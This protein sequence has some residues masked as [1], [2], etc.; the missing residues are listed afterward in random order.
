MKLFQWREIE[1]AVDYAAQG[2]QALHIH[3]FIID[4]DKAPACFKRDVDAGKQIA[5]LFDQDKNRL[6]ATARRLGVR[7]ILVEREGTDGMHIDL[8]GKPLERAVKECEIPGT[9]QGSLF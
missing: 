4:R 3:N 1:A 7:V 9:K 2:G 5:H 8:C 6:I